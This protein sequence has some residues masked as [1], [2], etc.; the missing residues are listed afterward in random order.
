MAILIISYNVDSLMKMDTYY[1][2]LN[3]VI[4]KTISNRFVF[5]ITYTEL[6]LFP[7]MYI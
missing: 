4:S 5:V 1:R 6:Q 2:L 3:V 7:H